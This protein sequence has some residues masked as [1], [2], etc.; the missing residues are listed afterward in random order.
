MYIVQSD[1][2]DHVRRQ[3]I[4]FQDL[5]VLQL[6]RHLRSL[7]L[8]FEK[9]LKLKL[10]KKKSKKGKQREGKERKRERETREIEKM[11]GN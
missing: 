6:H 7:R 8:K 4:P 2:D 3:V 1:L 11:R 5:V 10:K 9:I